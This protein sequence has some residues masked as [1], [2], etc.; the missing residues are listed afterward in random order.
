M[1][2][3]LIT[4]E[5][6]FHF[7]D[8]V[9]KQNYGY[10]AP[11]NPQELNQRHLHSEILTVWCGIV[12]FGSSWSLLHWRQRRCSCYCGIWALCGLRSYCEPELGRRGID[13]SSVWFQQ[14]GATAHTARAS[15]TVLREMF[16]Q[17]VISRAGDVPWPA[18]SPDLSACDYFLCGYIKSRIFISK[19]RTIEELKQ[20]ITEEIAAIPEQMTRR[21][22]ENL[23]VRLKQCLRKGG[24]H[25]GDVLSKTEDGMYWVFQWYQLL[26]KKV[27]P[28]CFISFWKTS[29]FSA[30]P[31]LTF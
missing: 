14:D 28:H 9:N 17:H 1:N 19:P 5:A 13:L 24:R 31:V 30:S 7:S 20:S 23:G 6:Y 2:T 21:V 18:L 12:S 11:E 25:V 22:M 26:H 3:V 4:H 8:Y 15:M 10:R 27:K 29:G 16:P